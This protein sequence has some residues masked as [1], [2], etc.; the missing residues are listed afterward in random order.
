[1]FVIPTVIS[2][3]ADLITIID[4][5]LKYGGFL[6]KDVRNV[7]EKSRDEIISSPKSLSVD[8]AKNIFSKQILAEIPQEDSA[9]ITKSI[10]SYLEII[11]GTI[12]HLEYFNK[13]E[14]IVQ[15]GN[16]YGDLIRRVGE[17]L[18]KWGCFEK[19]ADKLEFMVP[20]PYPKLSPVQRLDSMLSMPKLSKVFWEN[21]ILK[22]HVDK[23]LRNIGL[24]LLK[25]ITIDTVNVSNAT[26]LGLVIITNRKYYDRKSYKEL[27]YSHMDSL[28]HELSLFNSEN[29]SYAN[30]KLSNTEF[31]NLI[32]A[33]TSD[34]FDYVVKVNREYAISNNII[35]QL[36]KA[37]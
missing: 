2:T 26:T 15:Y 14:R 6:S 31:L 4:M 7:F 12:K 32:S 22:N 11:D 33:A 27:A 8:D 16:V 9:V 13:Q 17:K 35:S 25:T 29:F 1:M 5:A 24:G 34:F 36:K 20:V 37:G 3:I 30:I 21:K 23:N 19:W 28:G 10:G 18:N